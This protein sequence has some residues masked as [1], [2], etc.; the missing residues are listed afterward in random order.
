MDAN[1][2]GTSRRPS[3]EL[4]L[5]LRQLGRRVSPLEISEL[6]VFPPLSE[7]DESAEFLLFTRFHENGARRLCGARFV[8]R[9]GGRPETMEIEDVTEFGSVPS[10]RLPGLV[11][12][13]RRRLGDE[14][15]PVHFEIG[16]CPMNWDELVTVGP[17]AD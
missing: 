14:S 4:A 7:L 9:N 11:E 6:W 17:E 10:A 13:L 8:T 2:N 12:R 1:G 16:G 15:E 5:R 3:G